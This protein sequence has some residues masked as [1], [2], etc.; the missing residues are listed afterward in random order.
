MM[1]RSWLV[2]AFLVF[3][4]LLTEDTAWAR[5]RRGGNSGASNAARIRALQAQ[6]KGNIA[7]ATK[8]LEQATVVGVAAE[9]KMNEARLLTSDAADQGKN[10]KDN[11]KNE[12]EHMHSIEDQIANAQAQDS[13][14]MQSLDAYEDASDDY[15]DIRE[16]IL[17]S[18]DYKV[19]EARARAVPNPTEQRRQLDDLKYEM[20]T[21]NREYTTA[22]ANLE[23]SRS[24]FESLRMEL[25]TANSDWVEASKHVREARVSAADS[26][27]RL[28]GAGLK[29]MSAH[30]KLNAAI[31]TA[32]QAKQVIAVNQAVL[33]S[34]PQQKG[35]KP[36]APS[37]APAKKK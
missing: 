33:K 35:A 34:L 5:R 20:F 19:R 1:S 21:S 23:G 4:F 14:F 28:T 18:S 2:L 36:A 7:M 32:N 25:L 12:T 11:I 16:S 24:K 29:K 26:T 8:I 15:H 3:S 13:E 22:L 27:D 30:Q 31:E 37:K 10:A 9:G 17:N 6:A